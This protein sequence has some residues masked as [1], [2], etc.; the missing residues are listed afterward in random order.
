MFEGALGALLIFGMRLTD[1]SLGTLRMI[2]AFQGRSAVAAVIGFVEVT[3]FIVAIGK[4]MGNLDSPLNVL[5]YSGGFAG[6]TLLGLAIENRIA[7]GTRFVRVIT[8]RLNDRLVEALRDAGF[9]VTRVPGEGLHGR[10]YI[11]FSVVRRKDLGRYIGFVQELA[12]KA[13][14]TVEDA[15]SSQ[16]GFIGRRKAK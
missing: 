5:A 9:G 4:V 12:P 6:G 11:L 8:H 15:R 7:L 13:F 10:V 16:G 2:L 3:I 1:V 14:Y